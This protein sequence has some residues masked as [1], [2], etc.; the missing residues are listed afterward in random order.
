LKSFLFIIHFSH[1]GI[2]LIEISVLV[3]NSLHACVNPFFVHIRNVPSIVKSDQE[4]I[5][6]IKVLLA[7]FEKLYAVGAQNLF[8][9]FKTYL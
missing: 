6:L 7:F 4:Y 3:G 2:F 1:Q 5:P 9:H 8:L